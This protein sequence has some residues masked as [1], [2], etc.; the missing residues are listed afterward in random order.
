MAILTKDEQA[1]LDSWEAEFPDEVASFGSALNEKLGPSD[2]PE[3]LIRR[4][5][6]EQP[7]LWVGLMTALRARYSATQAEVE[8]AAGRAAIDKSG[9]EQVASVGAQA[10]IERLRAEV[11]AAREAG[12]AEGRAS[13]NAARQNQNTVNLVAQTLKSACAK[14]FRCDST[15]ATNDQL[16]GYAAHIVD[17]VPAGFGWR[18]NVGRI[19]AIVQRARDLDGTNSLLPSITA[20]D[21]VFEAEF[22]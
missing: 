4:F 11:E 18:D 3:G 12:R 10:E 5:Q 22:G 20:T 6:M 13:V 17:I 2:D 7:Q 21:L 14:N 9:A 15:S 16:M 1:L 19:P 8:R